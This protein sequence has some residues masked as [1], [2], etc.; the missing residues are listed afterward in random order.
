MSDFT[1]AAEAAS[2][3]P[4][5]FEIFKG[6]STREL[7]DVSVVLVLLSIDQSLLFSE[8]RLDSDGNGIFVGFVLI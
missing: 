8:G 3:F 5:T 1:V 7:I 6:P 4:I 2:V